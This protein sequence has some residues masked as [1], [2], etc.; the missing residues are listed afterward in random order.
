LVLC[1]LL[2]FEKDFERKSQVAKMI[3]LY[4]LFKENYLKKELG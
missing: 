1:F 2:V 3:C 4:F